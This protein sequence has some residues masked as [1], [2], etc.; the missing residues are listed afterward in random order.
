MFFYFKKKVINNNKT[1]TNK[2]DAVIVQQNFVL[3]RE[4]QNYK[5]D[6]HK[7]S[8]NYNTVK[9]NMTFATGILK[10]TKAGRFK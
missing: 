7:Y 8:T 1:S 9:T 6:H 3:S 10:N 2:V 4:I 5:I